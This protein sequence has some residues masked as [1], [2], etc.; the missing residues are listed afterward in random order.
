MAAGMLGAGRLKAFA[1]SSLERYPPTPS[2]KV[3]SLE[4]AEPKP[5][6]EERVARVAGIEAELEDL[7]HQV[8]MARAIAARRA[9]DSERLEREVTLLRTERDGFRRQFEER[10]RLLGVILQSGSF[11]LMQALRRLIGRE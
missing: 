11:R 6:I 5:S 10:N 3:V 8:D 4:M 2:D 9:R 7:R 1:R